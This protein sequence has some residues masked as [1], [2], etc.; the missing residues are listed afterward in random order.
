MLRK[1][2]GTDESKTSFQYCFFV[3]K[4]KKND[5]IPDSFLAVDDIET[6]RRNRIPLYLF[7]FLY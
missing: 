6:G 1:A 7:R 3:A 5:V 4:M 2:N